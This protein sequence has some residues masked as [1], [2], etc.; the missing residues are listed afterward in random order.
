MP[1]NENNRETGARA[2]PAKAKADRPTS[3]P[4]TLR[5]TNNPTRGWA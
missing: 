1:T 3:F 2:F 5:K 4:N